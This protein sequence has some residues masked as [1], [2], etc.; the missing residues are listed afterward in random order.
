MRGLESGELGTKRWEERTACVI[1]LNTRLLAELDPQVRSSGVNLSNR[2]CLPFFVL[3]RH[4]HNEHQH[5]WADLA[6]K[7]A[8]YDQTNCRD[9]VEMT[10]YRMFVRE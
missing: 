7:V 5:L 9:H 8:Y 2:P 10:C 4:D 3:S 1:F 6:A